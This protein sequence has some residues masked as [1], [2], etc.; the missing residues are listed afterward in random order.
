MEYHVHSGDD[1]GQRF[2][3]LAKEGLFLKDSGVVGAFL[4]PIHIAES[5][6]EESGRATGRLY[7]AHLSKSAMADIC[8][9]FCDRVASAGYDAMVYSN[10]N[11][12]ETGIDTANI[13]SQY[14]IWVAHY[15][16]QTDYSGE[17]MAW[18]YSST[19]IVSGISG[20]V[21][22]NYLYLRQGTSLVEPLKLTVG[23]LSVGVGQTD[24]VNFFVD[25]AL[26]PTAQIMFQSSNP[27]V[28]TVD[29]AGNIIGVSVGNA[30]V[31]A[32]VVAFSS[33]DAFVRY[34]LV[35]S[36]CAQIESAPPTIK[37]RVTNKSLSFLIKVSI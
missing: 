18:Q 1:I 3:L 20:S 27:Q 28:L 10:K 22:K 19:G 32:T 35:T 11:M 36:V 5:L 9:A 30:V 26:A 23:S 12:L 21:D 34:V 8:L 6:A 15:A 4:L 2:F 31:S 16:E 17:Y 13:A 7:N 14:G 37:A 24:K 25:P 33:N 29:T